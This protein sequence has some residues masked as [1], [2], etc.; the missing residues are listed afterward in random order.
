MA[1]EAKGMSSSPH[2]FFLSVSVPH[3]AHDWRFVYS[4]LIL[5][6]TV[7]MDFAVLS[8]LKWKRLSHIEMS[9]RFLPPMRWGISNPLYIS[10][11]ALNLSESRPDSRRSNNRRGAPQYTIARSNWE[12]YSITPKANFNSPNQGSSHLV[13][14]DSYKGVDV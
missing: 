6:W 4:P 8:Q 1:Q 9:I 3:F 2:F 7:R 10:Y 11:L 14:V 12:S 5:H 13:I